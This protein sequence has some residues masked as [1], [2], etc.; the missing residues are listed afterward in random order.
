M[1]DSEDRHWIGS[2]SARA[3][4]R[5]AL[6]STAIGLVLAVNIG[7]ALAGEDDDDYDDL[8]FEQKIIR[9]IMSGIGAVSGH[10]KGIDYRERSPLVVP[11]KLDL[12]PPQTTQAASPPN[13]PKDPDV[14]ERKRQRKLAKEQDHSHEEDWDPVAKDP[15]IGAARARTATASPQPGSNNAMPSD[16][17]SVLTPSQLGFKGFGNIFGPDKPEQ[18]PF[19][20]EPP[21]EA[22]TE[23]PTGYQTPS[24]AYAYGLGPDPNNKNAL[25]R[26][27]QTEQPAVIAP[28]KF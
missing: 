3:T 27:Y 23:P 18:A 11:P 16:F 6:L 12:P 22:L 26:T 15:A 2:K 14:A 17:G 1:S 20:A 25:G 19:T 5:A 7:P 9:N 24:P 8:S 28:G 4:L 21:R 13:W 10:E